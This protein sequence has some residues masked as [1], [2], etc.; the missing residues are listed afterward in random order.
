MK[1]KTIGVLSTVAIMSVAANA[2]ANVLFDVYLGATGGFGGETVF[3]HNDHENLSAMS[4][5]GVLGLDIPLARFELEY[6]FLDSDDAKLHLGM[7]NAYIKAPSAVLQP[8]LGV[9]IGSTFGGSA[10]YDNNL[11][12]LWHKRS[13]E[14]VDGKSLYE[15]ADVASKMA[16]QGML[17]LTLALPVLPIK[18]DV[19]GRVLYAPDIFKNLADTDADL[20]HYEGRVKLRYVF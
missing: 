14:T 16:Y 3:A 18:F 1:L 12:T 19:E 6:N 20:L 5:G 17:G 4:F 13:G 10:S 8:Y 15:D 7:I 2:N 9:G 11:K